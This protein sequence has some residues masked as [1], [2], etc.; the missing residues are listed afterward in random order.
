[1]SELCPVSFL[2]L[3]KSDL[4]PSRKRGFHRMVTMSLN[5]GVLLVRGFDYMVAAEDNKMAAYAA[6]T[7][8][9]LNTTHLAVNAKLEEREL[10]GIMATMAFNHGINKA[11]WQAYV[12]GIFKCAAKMAQHIPAEI[13]VISDLDEDG[14]CAEIERIYAENHVTTGGHVREWAKQDG[15]APYDAERVARER[16]AKE[17]ATKAAAGQGALAAFMGTKGRDSSTLTTVAPVALTTPLEAAMAAIAA[18]TSEADVLAAL[19]A[20]NT[21]L[22][23]FHALAASAPAPTQAPVLPDDVEAHPLSAL[24]RVKR[25]T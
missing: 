7:A 9:V 8:L 24:G 19:A 25:R 17:A 13:D 12:D 16:K 18:L 5:N 14:A 1:M 15:W 11:T 23:E 4:A 2:Y 6:F 21:K 22:A 20:L 3:A 10:R